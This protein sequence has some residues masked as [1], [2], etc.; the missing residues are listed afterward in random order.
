MA[1]L[2]LLSKVLIGVTVVGAVSSVVWHLGLK[3]KFGSGS[4]TAATAPASSMATTTQPPSPPPSPQ[5][6]PV[7]PAPAPVAVS[8]APVAPAANAANTSSGLSVAEHVEAGRKALNSGDF[9]QARSHLEQA[10][11]GGDGTAACLLGDMTIKGQGG[12][13]VNR[14]KAASLFQMAQSKNLI[15]FA[16]GS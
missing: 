2:T 9:A 10:V 4:S 11:Q 3:E 14:D 12:L 6:Q 16:A 7:Q 1:S 13:A 15:C 5:P 8:P